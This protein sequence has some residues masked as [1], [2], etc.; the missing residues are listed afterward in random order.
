MLNIPNGGDCNNKFLDLFVCK[1]LHTYPHSNTQK[2]RAHAH[3]HT[4]MHTNPKLEKYHLWWCIAFC[5]FFYIRGEPG[6]L[7][8]GRLKHSDFSRKPRKSDTSNF[9]QH[10][11]LTNPGKYCAITSFRSIVIP[12]NL[13]LRALSKI[14]RPVFFCNKQLCFL[15]H[16]ILI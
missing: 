4:H 2:K 9:V 7:K 10:A 13:F 14:F 11:R 5:I 1:N 15:F 8:H 16:A 3:T 6:R 12:T